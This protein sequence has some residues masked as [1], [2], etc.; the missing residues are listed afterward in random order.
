MAWN[1]EI[2]ASEPASVA[3]E[4]VGGAVARGAV[5]RRRVN[6]DGPKAACG[7]FDHARSAPPLPLRSAL[8]HSLGRCA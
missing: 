1:P 6:P 7:A 3:E 5:R 2:P 4:A 8:P